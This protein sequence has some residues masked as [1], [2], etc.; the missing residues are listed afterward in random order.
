MTQLYLR[1]KK[2]AR[3]LLVTQVKRYNC[4]TIFEITEK[5]TL[6]KF[7]G[8]AA[9]Q[10]QLNKIWNG[11]ILSNTSNLKVIA[12]AFIPILI[13]KIVSIDSAEGKKEHAKLVSKDSAEEKKEQAKLVSIVSAEEKKEQVELPIRKWPIWMTKIYYFYHSPSIKFLFSV[14]TYMAMLVVFSLFILTD[15]YPISEK[16]PSVKEYIIYTWAASTLTEEIRQAFMIRQISLSLMTWFSF[17]TL[18]EI[19]MYSML[20]A[21]VFL[22]LILSAEI[23]YHARMTYAITLGLFII[24]S[25]QFFLVSKHIG[26][27]V[28]MIGR[29]MF[30]IVF[31]LLIF[32]VFLFGFGVI[33]QSTMYPN[34]T[35]SFQLFKEIIYMPYWQLYGELFLDQFEGKEPSTCTDDVTLYQ[36][37]TIDRCPE[38]NQMNTVVLGVYM[39][40]THIILV[41]ILIAMFSH[42]FTT[43]QDNNELVWKF[44]RFSLVREYYDRSSLVPP[45]IIISHLKRA[46]LSI[47][48]KCTCE[49]K[50]QDKFKIETDAVEELAILEGSAVSK[51]HTSNKETEPSGLNT[52]SEQET[53]LSFQHQLNSVLSKVDSL[54][55]WVVRDKRK[56]QIRPVALNI[57]QHV[58]AQTNIVENE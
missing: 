11:R 51:Y 41:N 10:T 40:V 31:F 38:I 55:K 13:V 39:V 49:Y 25:M 19:V 14:V 1:E 27:K 29:M 2:Q 35:P 15:L 23:F 54:E 22:R 16:S 3:Q 34:S 52:S 58:P 28:I 6:M 32:A 5:F 50:K 21:S 46:F 44:H 12:A 9:C 53:D 8:H 57:K 42:T 30:D 20:T 17:W 48:S 4:I 47:C 18:F 26:P 33:Y 36:N 43:V 7:M 56:R 24:N 45:L 37:G